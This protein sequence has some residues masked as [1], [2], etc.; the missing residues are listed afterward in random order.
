MSERSERIIKHSALPSPP[1]LSPKA[2]ARLAIQA[3]LLTQVEALRR[4]E[5][6]VR[7]DA[8]DS[9]H[10]FRV[11]ARR[12]RSGLRTF[13]PLLERAWADQ[14][15][16]E[17]GWLARS[18]APARDTEVLLER[19]LAR[20]DHLPEEEEEGATARVR[21]LLDATLGGELVEARAAGV[22]VLDSDR[23]RALLDRLLAAA[24][25]PATTEAAD[26]PCRKALPPLARRAWRRLDQAV[27]GLDPGV[28]DPAW[29]QARIT[30]KRARYTADACA[31]A[32]G[33][34]AK[35]FA[36]E[37]SRV[38]DVLGEH[39][40]AMVAAATLTRL[41]TAEGVPATTAYWLGMLHEQERTAAATARATFATVWHDVRRPDLRRWLTKGT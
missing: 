11:A 33:K 35:R 13:R 19:L 12:L 29:H 20:A 39:Q 15:R 21:A 26:R 8:E 18:F 32:L 2:P 5:P 3:H 23:Y 30:A 40:D 1:P 28:S 37:L 9:V 22:G 41:A 25:D 16:S 36:K 14:L 38:T 31:P 24:C 17:L 4:Q 34:P 10:Q 27:V 6:R 7:I